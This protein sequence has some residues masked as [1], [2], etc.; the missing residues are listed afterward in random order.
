MFQS[1]PFYMKI[2]GDYA[3]F[4]DPMSKGSGEKFTY[5][6]PTVQALKGII[7]AVYWKPT[8]VY[9]VDEIKVLHPIQT[10]TKNIL[11]PMGNGGK[12]LSHYT[13]LRDVAY[14]VKF[15]FEWAP[16]QDMIPDR[17]EKKHEQIL[18]RSM[19][20][21]GRHDI[22]LGTRECIGCVERLKAEEYASLQTPFTG[23]VSLGIMF[24]SFSYTEWHK[25]DK[26][27]G[28]LSSL[29]TTVIMQDGVISCIRPEECPIRHELHNYTVKSFAPGTYTAVE[30]EWNRYENQEGGMKDESLASVATDVR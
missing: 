9:V 7:E 15:H 17:N 29:F 27:E 16:R 14:T 11:V 13:Y 28:T 18:L 5:Q 23:T 22:F 8:L 3:L 4:T 25:K 24:H 6:V 19:K 20:R 2:S 26:P 10:E 1:N 21:G 12:D 30:D